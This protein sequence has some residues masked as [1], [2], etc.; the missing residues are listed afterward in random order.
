MKYLVISIFVLLLF[1]PIIFS[2][3]LI[4]DEN[5]DTPFK[6][7]KFGKKMIFDLAE[8]KDT[9]YLYVDHGF[10]RTEK[11]ELK[12]CGIIDN[13]RICL[14][15]CNLDSKKAHIFAS[16]LSPEE[17]PE[18]GSNISFTKILAYLVIIIVIFFILRHVIVLLKERKSKKS[19]IKWD[20]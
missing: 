5:V 10:F 15:K 13:Y 6:T 14:E 17:M 12:S 18:K 19:K 1:I 3:K 9:C 2:S 7:E 8:K 20:F 11:I 16:R 4:F